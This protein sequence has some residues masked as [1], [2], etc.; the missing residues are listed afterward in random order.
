[1]RSKQVV[2]V[3]ATLTRTLYPVADYVSP[4]LRWQEVVLMLVKDNDFAGGNVTIET[5][6]ATLTEIVHLLI[7]NT[8]AE[9]NFNITCHYDI[10]AITRVSNIEN[11]LAIFKV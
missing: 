9:T 2:A 3:T 10:D 6:N 8:I 1:M 4:F 7:L 5:D 11:Y